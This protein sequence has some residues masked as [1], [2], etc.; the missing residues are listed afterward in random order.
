MKI[1]EIYVLENEMKFEIS[2][3]SLY[4]KTF[5]RTAPNYSFILWIH[6]S[7]T[8]LFSLSFHDNA[9]D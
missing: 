7:N 8:Y 2:N 1:G 4:T 3:R 6:Y 9:N 5:T